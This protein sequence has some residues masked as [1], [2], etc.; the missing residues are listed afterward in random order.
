M[1]GSRTARTLGML[2]SA[3]LALGIVYLAIGERIGVKTAGP[4]AGHWSEAAP[5]K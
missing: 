4:D 2:M 3:I 1:D 5:V